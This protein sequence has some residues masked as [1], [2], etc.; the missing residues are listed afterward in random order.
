M[1]LTAASLSFKFGTWIGFDE[2]AFELAQ[3]RLNC[4]CTAKQSRL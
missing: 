4:N 3:V 1:I 2:T